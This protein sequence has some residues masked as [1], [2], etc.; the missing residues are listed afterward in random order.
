MMP[1]RYL[2]DTSALLAHFRREPGWARVQSLFEE[3][4]TEILVA[5]V[6][7]TELA[8]RLREVGATIDEAR[9]TVQDYQDLM[10]EVVAVDGRIALMALMAFDLGCE[11]PERLPLADAL[12]AAAARE[13]GACLVHRDRHMAPIAEALV[14]QIDLSREPD[15]SSP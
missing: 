9:Q 1:R 2:L 12:I 13:R 6:S 7:L 14:E 8:R 10:S 3:E 15:P 5:S 11:T 4:N